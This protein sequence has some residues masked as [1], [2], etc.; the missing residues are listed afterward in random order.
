M[1]MWYVCFDIRCMPAGFGP[2]Y[3]LRFLPRGHCATKVRDADLLLSEFLQGHWRSACTA[4]IGGVRRMWRMLL[5]IDYY[6]PLYVV[7][8]ACVSTVVVVSDT[9]SHMPLGASICI[10]W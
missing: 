4:Y 8:G 2:M 7:V 10:D 1:S 6:C 9:A 3:D 5:L